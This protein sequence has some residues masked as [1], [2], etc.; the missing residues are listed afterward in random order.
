[1]LF[2]VKVVERPEFDAYVESLKA[3]GNTGLLDT[4]RTNNDGAIPGERTL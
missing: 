3:R 2:N 1:M 4:A